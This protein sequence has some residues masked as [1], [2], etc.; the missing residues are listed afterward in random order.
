LVHFHLRRNNRILRCN[1]HA[2]TLPAPAA[3]P[4]LP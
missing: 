2:R 4:T 1:D 3:G